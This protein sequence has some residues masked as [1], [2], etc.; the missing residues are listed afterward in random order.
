MRMQEYYKHCQNQNIHPAR[1]EVDLKVEKKLEFQSGVIA[2]FSGAHPQTSS[3][4]IKKLIE[5]CLLLHLL[6]TILGKVKVM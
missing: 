5:W 6:T 1:I 4:T 3:K 2:F